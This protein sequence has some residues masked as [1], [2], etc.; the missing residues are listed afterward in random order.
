MFSSLFNGL[1]NINK[2]TCSL[3]KNAYIGGFSG[4]IYLL[5]NQDF[6]MSITCSI[7]FYSG[8]IRKLKYM[9]K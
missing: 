2:H 5:E 9:L 7:F 1:K 3:E 8:T 4:K 6:R